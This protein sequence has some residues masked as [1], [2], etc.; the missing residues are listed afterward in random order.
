MKKL[1]MI[2]LAAMTLL[3]SSMMAVER[4]D[5]VRTKKE[6]TAAMDAANAAN[7]GDVFKIVCAWDPT[8]V[9]NVGNLKPTMSAGKLWITSDAKSLDQVP[10]MLIAFDWAGDLKDDGNFALVIEN[11]GLQYRN[12][13]EDRSGQIIYF[14][15]RDCQM[16][17]LVIRNCDISNYPRTLYRAVPKSDD[18]TNTDTRIKSLGKLVL[19]GCRVHDCNVRK[20]NNWAC[21]YPGQAVSEV[22]IRNNMFYDMPYCQAIFMMG[23]ATGGTGVEA[24]LNFENNTI[25]QAKSITNDSTIN[26][27]FRV[28]ETGAYFSLGSTYNINNN[29]FLAPQAGTYIDMLKNDTTAIKDDAVILN[30][31]SAIVYA[32]NNVIDPTAFAPLA[33]N[34]PSEESGNAWYLCDE[35]NTFTP[36]EAGITSWDAGVTF[37]DAEKSI[38]NMLKSSPAYTKGTNGTWLGAEMMYIDEFPVKA[39]LNINIAG[40]A[41][42]TYSVAP[43]KA[44]Y[45]VGDE[46]TVTLNSH[47]NFYRQFNTFKGWSDGN[48][49]EVRNFKLEGDLNLTATYEG[50]NTIVSAF[51]FSSITG[52]NMESYD[53]DIYFNMDE[54]YKATVK[55]FVNDT[56]STKVAPFSYIAGSFQTR[57]GKFG[58]DDE[59]VQM[60]IISRRTA[61]IAKESQRD[62]AQIELC[63]KDLSNIVV[64][65]FVGTDNNAA[66]IQALDYSLNGETWTRVAQVEIKNHQWAELAGTLPADAQGKD[67]VYVRIIG[68]LSDGHVVTDDEGVGVIVGGVEDTEAYLALDAFEYIGNILI[69]AD[70]TNGIEDV[71]TSKSNKQFNENAPIYNMMGVRVAKGTKGILIQNGK[72]FIVK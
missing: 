59:E 12:G 44:Q 64:S 57:A 29:I 36:E 23:Y 65:A 62:Y 42:I 22:N 32:S 21:I 24:T 10:Q 39:A 2:A 5:T 70:T 1:S 38:Y 6:F 68:D 16:D 37:Q 11:V 40:P 4:I 26:N 7:A 43:E 28:I 14:N 52:K 72:K 18:G 50:D 58:E 19:E 53:A 31:N 15:K 71:T 35:A 8:E 47:N 13:K 60:P 48:N 34:T 61:A 3:P 67:K 27:R 30:A 63:T 55:A 45:Y 20:D 49:E 25:L 54:A 66:K 46:V 9:L 51:D 56:A 17:S 69:T 41:Y 33:T